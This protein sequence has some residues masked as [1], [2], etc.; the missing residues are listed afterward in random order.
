MR[1]TGKGQVTI[2]K[3]I[4]RFAADSVFCRIRELSSSW[5]VTTLAFA[6]L[7]SSR[8]KAGGEAWLS[9][10]SAAPLTAE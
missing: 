2:P 9:K 6:R 10:A 8:M 7:D 3:E 1:I 4:R 5:P